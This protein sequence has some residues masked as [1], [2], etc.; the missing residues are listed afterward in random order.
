MKIILLLLMLGVF[1]KSPYDAKVTKIY[2]ADTYTCD[3]E[4]GLDIVLH[5]QKIRLLNINAPEMRGLEKLEGKLAR[6]YV[7]NLIFSTADSAVILDITGK[8]KYGRWIANVWIET[9][10]TLMLI[11]QH[12]VDQKYAVKKIYK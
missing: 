2:D 10:D 1:A 4:L 3:I 5:N 12:L 6:D 7:R 9:K 11:N 8:G